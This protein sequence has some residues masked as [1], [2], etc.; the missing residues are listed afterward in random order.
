MKDSILWRK[1]VAPVSEALMN[2][3]TRIKDIDTIL[4]L[5]LQRSV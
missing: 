2:N 5:K 4:E 1:G 3:P